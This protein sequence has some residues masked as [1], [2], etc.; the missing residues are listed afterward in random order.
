[1][2]RGDGSNRNDKSID[3]GLL[4]DE[5]LESEIKVHPEVR[6]LWVDVLSKN[7]N[8]EKGL[9][10]KYVAPT[11]VN[12]EVEIEIEEDDIATEIKFWETA[13][14]MLGDRNNSYYYATL[15]TKQN[16]KSMRVL[17]MIDGVILADQKDI[18]KEVVDFYGSLMGMAANNLKHVDI[19]AIKSCRKINME[20]R[21][22][23]V[24][25]VT[26]EEI[27]KALQGIGDLK[28]PGIDGYGAKFFKAS[29]H[30]IKGDVIA[31]F[32]EFFK[33]GRMYKAFNSIVLTLIPKM[34]I[35]YLLKARRGIKQGDPISPLL[36]VIMMEYMNR[37][38]T[39]M[40]KD[41]NFNHHAKCE[42]LSLTNLTFADDVL[43]F[44]IGDPKSM[45]MML[46]A[47]KKLY[48]STSLIVNLN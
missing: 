26:K 9:A 7:R 23:L 4:E 11:L 35:P 27:A 13:L 41:H 48:E 5:T 36:F 18:E 24:V 29:Y 10:I 37:S 12:G 20:Q 30:I 46:D 47:F 33:K 6:K 43:L 44:I 40:Q 1:M 25:K 45:E 21:K 8:L 15:K 31:A 34:R 38:L 28:A 14:I 16:G 42:K 32:M 39:K 19:E 17:H 3:E 2:V 22:F